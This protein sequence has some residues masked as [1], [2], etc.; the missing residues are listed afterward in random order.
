MSELIPFPDGE[1]T[2]A[3]IRELEM[4]MAEAE[5][6]AA[7][8]SGKPIEDT[9]EYDEVHEAQIRALAER[10]G[11][12][13]ESGPLFDKDGDYLCGA[14]ALRQEP[15]ACTHVSGNI[16]METGSCMIWCTGQPLNEPIGK[17]LTQIEA[18]YAMRPTAKGF[19]CSRCEYS[20]EAKKPD[21]DGRPSWCTVW[22]MHIEPKAC[23]IFEDGDDLVS[24][25]SN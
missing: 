10:V 15:E 6:D 4:L 17:Q 1:S 22:G 3:L 16:S 12:Y 7:E 14:C 9:G 2:N 13:A 11:F 5:A 18:N 20:A 8:A 21:S 25:G 24:G 23:C 19:G